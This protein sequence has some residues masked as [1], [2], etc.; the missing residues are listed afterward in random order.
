[1]CVGVISS[2][3]YWTMVATG[4]DWKLDSMTLSFRRKETQ[5]RSWCRKL[6]R[7]QLIASKLAIT[8]SQCGLFY[9]F[10]EQWR[11]KR[12]RDRRKSE[13]KIIFHLPSNDPH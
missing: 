9:H 1:M 12:D 6:E 13:L 4:F 8:S 2:S 3:R 10:R 11:A 5:S 7:V